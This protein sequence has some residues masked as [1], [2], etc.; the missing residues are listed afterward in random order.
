MR[1]PGLRERCG[2]GLDDG[3]VRAFS[4]AVLLRAVA[5]AVTRLDASLSV[6]RV[7]A[8]TNELAAL[9]VLERLDATTGLQLSERLEVAE[10]VEGA[11][12]LAQMV[13]SVEPA[14]VVMERDDI[15]KA[16]DRANRHLEQV[17]MHQIQHTSCYSASGRER[18]SVHLASQAGLADGIRL[19][20][21]SPA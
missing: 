14:G 21:A 4:D 2:D 1:Q 16:R 19:R 5:R 13:R 10:G 20:R 18:R 9:V 11:V 15:A 17:S 7:P 3:A 6:Q 8:A 12:L